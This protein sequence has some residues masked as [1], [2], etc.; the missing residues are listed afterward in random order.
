MLYPVLLNLCSWASS[1][2]AFKSACSILGAQT[3]ILEVKSNTRRFWIKGPFRAVFIYRYVRVQ[4]TAVV[5]APSTPH[6]G[7]SCFF[8]GGVF[9]GLQNE[10]GDNFLDFNF[11]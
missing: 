7:V 6:E 4:C 3:I 5:E 8:L 11:S 1:S 9:W 10:L 2:K